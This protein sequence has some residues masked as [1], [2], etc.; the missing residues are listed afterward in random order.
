MTQLN[1]NW[2]NLAM[3]NDR[4][5][6]LQ[7]LDE[8]EVMLIRRRLGSTAVAQRAFGRDEPLFPDRLSS[9]VGRQ[10]TGF[11]GQFKYT[12][13]QE[14]AATLFYGLCMGH[15]FE[16]GNKRTALVSMLVLLDRNGVLLVDNNEHELYDLA[17][18][19]AAHELG[20]VQGDDEVAHIA[21]WLDARTREAKPGQRR[22]RFRE[23][24]K[25]LEDQGC[26]FG[27]PK[28]NKIRI[29]RDTPDGACSVSAGYPNE[30]HDVPLNEMRRI[31]R[32]L[33][34]DLAHGFDAGALFDFEASVD[35]F[36]NTYRQL[37]S[38]LA[39]M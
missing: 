26:V 12:T 5:V 14:I 34:L 36:V 37:M 30:H 2:T 17:T 7:T 33:K 4:Y 16:N 22:M 19:T 21:T 8:D 23:F 15:A 28:D 32:A 31:R 24:R 35:G 1:P 39:D 38:R 6:Q 27:T 9:A 29:R 13:I 25:I 3:W 20:V 10:R 18:G 11:G